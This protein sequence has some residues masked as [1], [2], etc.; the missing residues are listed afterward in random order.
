MDEELSNRLVTYLGDMA[1]RGDEQAHKLFHAFHKYL[2][3][4]A[5]AEDSK[6]WNRHND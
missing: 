5:S 6:E 1:S 4:E 3:D 2:A